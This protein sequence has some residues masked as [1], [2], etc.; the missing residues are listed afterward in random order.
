MHHISDFLET[1]CSPGESP[2][3]QDLIRKHCVELPDRLIKVT[4]SVGRYG[5]SCFLLS[6]IICDHWNSAIIK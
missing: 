2:R 3:Q 4:D 1:M 6:G 5:F